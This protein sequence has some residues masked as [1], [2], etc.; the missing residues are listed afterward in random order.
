M[1]TKQKLSLLRDEIDSIDR[2]L[3]A[4]FQRRMSVSARVGEVKTAGNIAIQDEGRER[5][6]IDNALRASAPENHAD[7]AALMRNIMAFSRMRQRA[8][9]FGTPTGAAAADF[10]PP[11]PPSDTA[12]MR[13]AR[14]T[15]C[16]QGVRGAWGEVGSGIL[17]PHGAL[18]G[19]ETFEDVFENVKNG[20]C[21]FG[22][23]PIENSQTGAIGEVYDLLRGF[24][25]YIV[26]Q[27]WVPIAQCFLVKKGATL[28]DI[29]EVFS[30]PQGFG[31]C[32]RFLRQRNWDLTP[33]RNTALAAQMVSERADKRAAA[34]GSRLAAQIYDL[35]V[36]VPDVM[37]AAG[38]QTRF[39]TIAARPCYDAESTVVSVTFSTTH[40]AGALC[41][42]LQT[43]MLAGI[44]LSRIESRPVSVDRY[45]FFADLRGNI[46]D[47]LM[48]TTLRQAAAQRAYF[49]I[50]GCYQA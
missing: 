39:I 9:T 10:T 34:I 46:S 36:L 38:N 27:T 49:E 1:D 16:F 25:C 18:A 5:Q 37:D 29:R 42:V 17:F 3:V 4:L 20:A 32:R 45:R 19:A 44:N 48:M 2:E 31:Q 7:V 13:K 6:V 28:D 12:L 43:F 22:V 30:H 14:P 47:E 35:D 21:D 23:V 15:V 26:G 24:G 40:T 33:C 11:F 8:L 41:A 50:L